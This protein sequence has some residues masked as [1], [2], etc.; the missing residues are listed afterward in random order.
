MITS[1]SRTEDLDIEKCA[2]H[3]GGIYY[4]VWHAVHESRKHSTKLKT[5]AVKN[6]DALLKI[7]QDAENAPYKYYQR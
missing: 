2:A 5:N 1:R 6:M 3:V 7:Q 4:L